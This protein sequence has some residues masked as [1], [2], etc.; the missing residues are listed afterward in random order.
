[1]RKIITEPIRI[2]NEVVYSRDLKVAIC[3]TDTKLKEYILSPEIEKIDMNCFETNHNMESII[4]P[5]KKPLTIE[6]AAFHYCSNLKEIELPNNITYIEQGAF[7]NCYNLKK[8][9]F[10]AK[11]DIIR[12]YIFFNCR[13]LEEITLPE[14]VI[15]ICP[16]TF[17]G[18]ISL[19]KIVLPNSLKWIDAHSFNNC[20][21][22]KTI[23]L[24]KNVIV[25]KAFD[26]TIENI[27]I[28]K[29][30]LD[31]NPDFKSLYEGKFKERK[32][33][34]DLLSEGKSLKEISNIY[35]AYNIE[36]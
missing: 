5:N 18:C 6:S 28:D 29:E 20:P 17:C 16:N 25:G 31:K 26:D 4:L 3:D 2:V 12:S 30:T 22:L 8:V 32:S 1:M 27:Y 33:L 14:G 21:N 24:P 36:K 19:K 9:L 15:E 34:D 10:N 13:K 35:K 7:A 11:D 23:S